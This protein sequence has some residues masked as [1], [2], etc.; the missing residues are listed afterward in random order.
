[1]WSI[2]IYPIMLINNINAEIIKI[3]CKN[4][5]S[6][7]DERL[8]SVML[9]QVWY[10]NIRNVK[11]KIIS[12][13]F[14]KKCCTFKRFKVVILALYST[15]NS[16]AIKCSVFK[17]H[18]NDVMLFSRQIDSQTYTNNNQKKRWI[19]DNGIILLSLKKKK[20]PNTSNN[21]LGGREWC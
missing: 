13:K 19:M 11:L 15:E 1:M 17:L 16:G 6:Q 10:C 3:W 2:L 18:V 9:P 7:I 21:S 5:Q 12:K 20:K 14:G 8:F 4:F